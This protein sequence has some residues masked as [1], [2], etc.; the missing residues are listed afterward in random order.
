MKNKVL[1]INSNLFIILLLLFFTS[2]VNCSESNPQPEEEQQK[3]FVGR[4][5]FLS[6]K[7]ISLTDQ[8]G[9][10]LMLRGVSL[11]WH[12]WWSQFY[13]KETV[14]WLKKDWNANIIRAAIGVDPD[15]AY[16]DNPEKAMQCLYTV[17]DA[18]IENDMYVIIDWHSHTIKKEEAIAFFTLVSS[19]YKDHPNIIYEIFNEPEE[20]SW[21]EIKAYSEEMIKTIRQIDKKNIILVGCP[22]WDQD[23]HLVAD[24]PI[25]GHE[26]IMYTVHFYAATHK[27]HLRD[28]A[29]YALKKGIPVF[30]SECASMEA[31]GDGPIDHTS[32]QEWLVWMEANK[33][34]WV[35]WSVSGKDETC[36]M[37]KDVTSPLTGW[38]EN[39]LKPWGRIVKRTLKE[40]NG[41]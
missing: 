13:N 27:K 11:G 30:I 29:D 14:A 8:Q 16:I 34:S 15:G 36:S 5:G 7:G 1:N 28:R 32:W 37:V 25:L 35:T 6:V 3:G 33:L 9:E 10:A 41:R 18:A 4:H 17:I 23:I 22:H 38:T 19:K 20:Q 31:T 2:Y 21:A 12:N 24:D 39:D 26:N 40:Y